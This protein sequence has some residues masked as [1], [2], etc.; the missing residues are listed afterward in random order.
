V[1]E[2]MANRPAEIT[3][4]VEITPQREDNID[5]HALVGILNDHRKFILIGTALFFLASVLYVFMATP[6]YQASAMVQVERAAPSVI[7]Q[8]SPGQLN[9]A[10]GSQAV[11]EIPLLTSR[12]SLGEAVE[13]LNLDIHSEAQRFPLIGEFLARKYSP[14]VPGAVASPWFGLDRYGWGG[15]DLEIAELEVPDALLGQPLVLVAGESGQYSLLDGEDNVLV[16]GRV[17]QLAEGDNVAMKV[18]TLRA[19]PGTRFDVVRSS[20]IGA[21]GRLSENISAVERGTESGI[22]ALTYENTDPILAAQVLAQITT[23]YLRQSVQR[24]SAEAENRLEF[25]NEQLPKV[26][27]DLEEAQNALNAFQQ[28]VG[29]V[30]ISMK[31]QALLNQTVALNNSIQQLRVQQPDVARRFTPAHPA[32]QSLQQQIGQ[33]EAEKAELQARMNELPD[34]QQGLYRLTR[35][36]EVTNRTYTN[37]LDQAQQLDIARASAIGNVQVI[38]APAVNV[39]QPV[40]PKPV[41]VIGGVTAA[42]AMMLIA[43]VLTRQVL[44]RSVEDPADIE[45]L[46][47][48][49]Y[50]SI[51]LSSQERANALRPQR[52]QSLRPNLLA[53]SAPSDLA[54]EALRGLRTSLHFA[55]IEP[56]N[57]LLMIAGPSAGVGKTFVSSNLAVTIAQAGQ[58]VLL[59]DADMRRGTLHEVMGTRWEDGLSELISGQIQLEA[60]VRHVR[61]TENLSFISRGKVPPNPSE[62]LMHPDFAALLQELAPLYDLV[63][64]DTPPVLAVTDAAVIGHHVGTTLLVVRFGVNQAR[65]VALAKQRLEQN[66]VKVKGAIVNAVQRRSAGHYSYSYSYYDSR[67]AKS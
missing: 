21:I 61:G 33:L 24:N 36:V 44:N 20:Y 9:E 28:R 54:M 65:E 43:F 67:P 11:T 4:Q 38:D 30:D 13:N 51:F 66:G 10:A 62:L 64:I 56:K 60:A 29:T 14:D 49:V 58:R 46:G 6:K 53:F 22:I 42:G 17:G 5:V 48:P 19:N 3:P 55:R 50:A 12:S 45:Q 52:R 16:Q 31:T 47:L 26:Q 2:L 40:W 8:S 59:I 35:D 15:E 37:L 39:A 25:V 27:A 32:Y 7:G 1:N 41:P 63:I 57:N 34:I 23:S 18:E